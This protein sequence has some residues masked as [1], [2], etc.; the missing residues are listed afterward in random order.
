MI[1]R[2]TTTSPCAWDEA[3]AAIGAELEGARFQDSHL[4]FLGTGEPRDELSLC[5]VGAPLRHNNLPDSSNMCHETTS[6]ALKKTLGVARR[7]RRLRRSSTNVTPCS[8]SART[9]GRIVR[10]SFIRCRMRPSAAC[11]SSPS[12]RCGSAGSRS[13]PIRKIAIEMLTGGQTRISSQYHQVKTGG[14]IAAIIGLLQACLGGGRRAPS[15]T[16]AG[17][18]SMLT[19]IEQSHRRLRIVRREGARHRVGGDRGRSQA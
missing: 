18:L 1:P 17:A 13:S 14:D 2:P 12:T 4:L 6:V 19:F 16:A 5:A 15:A 9:P 8:F 7:H 3:F 10:A 11:R